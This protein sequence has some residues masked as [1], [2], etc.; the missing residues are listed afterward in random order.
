MTVITDETKTRHVTFILG[1]ILC[2]VVTVGFV[3]N[4]L[5]LLIW[6]NG[7]RCRKLPGNVY[8]IALSIADMFVLFTGGIYFIFD[9]VFQIKL[10]DLNEIFCKTIVGAIHITLLFSIWTTMCLTLERTVIILQ[11]IR[12][13]RCFSR[14]RTLTTLLFF[15]VMA[16]LLSLPLMIGKELSDVMLENINLSKHDT[17]HI[18][19]VSEA[20]VTTA[21]HQTPEREITMNKHICQTVKDS[22]LG[23]YENVFHRYFIDL[24]LLFLTPLVTLMTCNI[25]MGLKLFRSNAPFTSNESRKHNTNLGPVLRAVTVRVLAV[26]IIHCSTTG[27]YSIAA[28]IPGLYDAKF[29]DGNI[30]IFWNT[31]QVWWFVNNAA[32]FVM[33][34]FTGTA[35]R[36]DLYALVCKRRASRSAWRGPYEL[37]T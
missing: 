37:D 20:N 16:T 9:F 6:L 10:T 4:F 15:A 32:N 5:S 23:E 3:G 18:R 34:N 1:I 8:F 29:T 22:F 35:F 24:I 21:S 17:V 7:E 25:I 30:Q 28:L 2:V 13:A 27:P 31:L 11:P 19:N 36:R 26:N 12:S 14:K 33:Y